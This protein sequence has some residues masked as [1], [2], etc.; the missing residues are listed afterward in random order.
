MSLL[1]EGRKTLV[2]AVPLV[3][4]QVSQMAM[5][6]VDTAMIGD[7]GSLELAASAFAN[8]V[9]HVPMLAAAGLSVAVSVKTSQARGAGD[10]EAAARAVRHGV[11]LALGIG[12]LTLV[13]AFA[14][15]PLLGFFRQDPDVIARVPG[16]FLLVAASMVPAFALMGLKNHADA[17]N[18][19]WWP[20]GIVVAGVAFNALLNWV[21][22]RGNWG[23]PA[24]GLEG[25]GV[26]T[27]IARM[28]TVAGL[29]WWMVKSDVL[30]EWMPTRWLGR[31]RGRTVRSLAR[32]GGPAALQIGA[33]FGAFI[34]AALI[35]GSM[36]E[37]ELAAHQVAFTF[38][39]TLYMIPLGFSMA[40][41]VR[42]GDAKGAGELGRL[43]DILL[44]TWGMILVLSLS[45]MAGLWF[46]PEVIA[47][48]FSDDRET[49]GL[50]A[51]ILMVTAIFQVGDQSQIIFSGYLRGLDD[52]T[53]PAVIMVVCYWILGMPFGWWLAFERGMGAPGIW[54]GL[55]LGLWATAVG[56]GVRILWKGRELSL[57]EVV[58]ED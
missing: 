30:G 13:G 39:A 54:W 33:E 41:T 32:I 57:R 27:L 50:A 45:C 14:L 58:A 7:V 31:L 15:L 36:G 18:R 44:S 51:A 56:L 35:I 3:T 52:V 20:M 48:W 37:I 11:W 22:I 28:A 42:T 47:D 8:N 34:A 9:L 23:A 21:L 6:V 16:Y 25:A 43:R 29:F 38:S 19:P 1:E 40:L 55:T 12:L 49:I 17:L 24:L 46:F 2:L 10:R 4:S 5:A 53:M 26:A